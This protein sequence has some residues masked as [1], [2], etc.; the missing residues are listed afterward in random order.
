MLRKLILLSLPLHGYMD[1]VTTNSPVVA[2]TGSTGEAPAVTAPA[3]VDPNA[4]LKR[5]IVASFPNKV[6]TK[7]VKFHFKKVKTKDEATG[8]ESENKRPTVELIIPVPSIEGIIEI[9]NDPKALDENGLPSKE[10]SLMLEAIHDVVVGRAREIIN[11]QDGTNN[12]VMIQKQEDFPIDELSW[13]KIANLPRDMRR[14]G[15]IS[16]ETWEDF[17]K[18]Y[19]EVMPAVSGKTPDQV[20]NAAK[21]LLNKFNAVKTNK[22]VLKLLKEQLGLY[23]QHS[24]NAETYED[25]VKFLMEKADTL[26]NMDEASL[27]ANL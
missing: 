12:T 1:E 11:E 18:D 9:L 24:P 2:S 23:C 16:K 26:L 17:A 27:L 7:E 4:E 20:G 3:V 21:I 14:G 25:S 10:L 15:G 13:A 19:I 5:K 6:D 8:L 22:P